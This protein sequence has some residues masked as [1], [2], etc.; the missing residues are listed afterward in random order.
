MPFPLMQLS[1]LTMFYDIL[2]QQKSCPS[3]EYANIVIFLT[4]LVRKMLKK[5]KNQP[6]LFVE[7]LF[8][9]TR[10]ECHYSD[11]E[12]LLHE[13]GHLRKETKTWGKDSGDVDIGS[14][15][16][17]KRVSIADALGDDEAD[18]EITHVLGNKYDLF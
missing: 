5:M 3:K 12:Y 18:V 16:G 14:S 17:W 2:V 1:L 10:K 6:L 15:E 4:S 8:W 9:K 13:P 7:I 11:S